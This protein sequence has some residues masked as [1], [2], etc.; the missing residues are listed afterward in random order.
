EIRARLAVTDLLDGAKLTIAGVVDHDVQSTEVS[1]RLLDGLSHARLVGE[2]DLERENA[3]AELF[4]EGVFRT[5]G[6]G[7]FRAGLRQSLREAQPHSLGAARDEP[8]AVFD[9]GDVVFHNA[10]IMPHGGATALD[11]SAGSLA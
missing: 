5:R 7:D 4:N 6:D 2:I 1:D 11:C 8:D 9:R 10:V 3:V